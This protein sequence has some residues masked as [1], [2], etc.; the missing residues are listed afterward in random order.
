VATFSRFLAERL[1]SL[2][3]FRDLLNMQFNPDWAYLPAHENR[4]YFRF[5]VIL[6]GGEDTINLLLMLRNGL[7]SGD[8]YF[9][10]CS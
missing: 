1:K 3:R 10:S 8:L 2:L 7:Y 9:S 5:N 4:A 6:T